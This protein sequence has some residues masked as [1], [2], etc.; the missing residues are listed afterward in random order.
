MPDVVL[1]LDGALLSA[2]V[3]LLAGTTAVALS[4]HRFSAR[5]LRWRLLGIVVLPA[6]AMV[7]VAVFR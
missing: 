1:G 2:A 3:W 4:A 6:A 7:A 5:Q